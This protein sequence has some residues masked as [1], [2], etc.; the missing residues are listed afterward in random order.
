[1]RLTAQSGNCK[2]Q[3]LPEDDKSREGMMERS[4]HS[5]FLDNQ[6]S[7]AQPAGWLQ[8]SKFGMGWKVFSLLNTPLI[9]SSALGWIELA[10]HFQL[11]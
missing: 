7:P 10:Q 1:M 8:K 5:A 4:Q 6:Y 11:V 3:G 9:H 2:T